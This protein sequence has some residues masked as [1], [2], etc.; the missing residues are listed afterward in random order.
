MAVK[1]VFASDQGITGSRKG[2]FASGILQIYPNGSAPMFALTAG[3]ESKP[4]TDV[5]VTW[6]EENHISGRTDVNGLVTDGDG[7]GFILDDASSYVPGVIVLVE[8]TGEYLFINNVVGNTVTVQRGFADSSPVTIDNTMHFQRIGTATEEASERPVAVANLGYPRFNYTQIFRNAW[9]ISGTA[10]AVEWHT[11]SQIAKSRAD[12]GLFHAEDIERSIIWGRKSIGVM[13]NKPF[14]TMDGINTQITSNVVA[15]VGGVSWA[16]FKVWMRTVFAKNIK[17]KP[18]E[19]IGYTSNLGIAILND[20]VEMNSQ[21]NIET[22]QGEF[23]I[24]VTRFISPFG[25]ISFLTHPLMNESEAWQGDMYIYHPGAI[26]TR[27]LR[28]TKVKDYNED[29]GKDSDF[30]VYTTEL[31]AEYHAEETG[32]K[33][34]GMTHAEANT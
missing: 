32:M 10:K 22:G 21:L 14:R 23:G 18:N 34:L 24:R 20:L 9:D 4:A 1:G 3:M 25:T 16:D 8:E 19:R 13:N 12:A 30:G 17:G 33:I 6:F 29:Q 27:Y 11:G 26:R 15:S 7:T 5:V 2:D 28:R 31:C